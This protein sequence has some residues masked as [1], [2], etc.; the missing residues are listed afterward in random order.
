VRAL[1][2]IKLEES[3]DNPGVWIR[4]SSGS[5]WK[6]LLRRAQEF[7]WSMLPLQSKA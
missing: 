7:M 6:A 2:D 4:H 5:G 3:Q 1:L